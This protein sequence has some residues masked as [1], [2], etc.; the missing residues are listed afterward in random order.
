MTL[1][2]TASPWPGLDPYEEAHEERFFGR[3]RTT[4]ALLAVVQRAP[5]S[6]FYGQSGLGKTSLLQAGLFPRLR[7]RNHLPVRIRLDFAP[8]AVPLGRQVLAAIATTARGTQALDDPAQRVVPPAELAEGAPTSL[9]TYFHR[10]GQYFWNAQSSIVTPVLV[11]DQFEEWFG[12]GAA[13]PPEERRAFLRELHQLLDNHPPDDLPAAA[14]YVYQGV[15]LALLLVLREDFLAHLS[16]LRDYLPWLPGNELRLLPFTAAQAREVVEQPALPFWPPDAGF[17]DAVL[18]ALRRSTPASPFSPG[19]ADAAAD[20]DPSILSLLLARLFEPLRAAPDGP[21]RGRLVRE[22]GEDVLLDFYEQA[23]A[24]ARLTRLERDYLED[25]LVTH[26]GLRNSVALDDATGGHSVRREALERLRDARVLHFDDR[27]LGHDRVELA[28]D[29]LC[30]TV[31]RAR[32]LRRARTTRRRWRT[33][34]VLFLLVLLPLGWRSWWDRLAE[35]QKRAALRLLDEGAQLAHNGSVAEARERY[36]AAIAMVQRG[37]LGSADRDLTLR[38]VGGS[39]AALGADLRKQYKHEDATAAYRVAIAAYEAADTTSAAVGYDLAD[40]QFWF[41]LELETVGDLDGA[42]HAA[43]AHRDLLRSLVR[44]WPSEERLQRDLAVSHNRVC[45]ILRQQQQLRVAL[46]ECRQGM[47][48]LAVLLGRNPDN[49]ELKRELATAYNQVGD[50]LKKQGDLAG[51]FDQFSRGLSLRKELASGSPSD[52]DLQ[53]ALATSYRLVGGALAAQGQLSDAQDSYRKG[54]ELIYHS[55][56]D[57]RPE[58]CAEAARIHL[59]WGRA[60]QLDGR[61]DAALQK[62]NQAVDNA[63]L[64]STYSPDDANYKTIQGCVALRL[65]EVLLAVQPQQRSRAIEALNGGHA[66]LSE[67]SSK[68]RLSPEGS[69]CLTRINDLL[70]PKQG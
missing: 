55:C 31:L 9:W 2:G 14:T 67:L 21:S 20:Y 64:A 13:R 38:Q 30:A 48:L 18:A 28:H 10:R 47:R 66:R 68:N 53:H 37:E 39:A 69:E 24:R 17:T 40:A 15:P 32:L 6:V 52:G 23:L 4:A 62:I 34:F 33:L 12:H 63:T 50:V 45:T 27:T 44:E 59:G 5:L 54:A 56:T 46:E 26:S 16:D 22:R 8:S 19:G 51:A 70:Q 3:E 65:G 35:A 49:A 57:V 58:P 41:G 61:P 1:S 11:F 7:A 43:Q 25:A 42:L 29:V 36:A 60:L